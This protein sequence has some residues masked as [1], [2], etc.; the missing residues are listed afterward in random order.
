MGDNSSGSEYEAPPPPPPRVKKSTKSDAPRDSE[1]DKLLNEQRDKRDKRREEDA[2]RSEANSS[3]RAAMDGNSRKAAKRAGQPPVIVQ[4]STP[5]PALKSIGKLI[6]LVEGP[7]A[8]KDAPVPGKDHIDALVEQGFCAV[9]VTAKQL[10]IDRSWTND[11][12]LKL[13]KEKLPVAYGTTAAAIAAW[14]DAHPDLPNDR[15]PPVFRVLLQTHKKLAVARPKRPMGA[16]MQDKVTS[17]SSWY[18]KRLYISGYLLFLP[19]CGTDSSLTASGLD[20]SLYSEDE[21]TTYR[22]C[23]LCDELDGSI[24]NDASPVDATGPDASADDEV[25]IVASGKRKRHSASSL[26]GT[27]PAK[28]AKREPSVVTITDDDD[29]DTPPVAG[30][31]TVVDA[32]EPSTFAA[33]GFYSPP[34]RNRARVVE[35]YA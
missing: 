19:A 7:T 4:D 30:P 31:S 26:A 32:M 25:Q 23:A 22:P 2:A 34:K 20:A 12:A 24:E 28:R 27:K 35:H 3:C 6:W 16:D 10:Q 14:K 15:L 29:D 5:A 33:T 1:L 11:Q 17:A 18:D 8:F 21:I 9:G 13:L